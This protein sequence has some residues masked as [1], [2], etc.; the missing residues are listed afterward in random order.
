MKATT[1]AKEHGPGVDVLD[2][3]ASVVCKVTRTGYPNIF[4]HTAWVKY[5]AEHNT[6]GLK[7]Q[8]NQTKQF[9]VAHFSIDAEPSTPH[10]AM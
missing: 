10:P 2:D 7:H 9:Y 6:Q 4:S 1:F 5:E 3:G 8:H